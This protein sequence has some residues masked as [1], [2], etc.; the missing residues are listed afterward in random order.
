MNIKTIQLGSLVIALGMLGGCSFSGLD[1]SNKFSCAAPE[2]VMCDS[3]GG[4]YA[5]MGQKTLPGQ[6]VNVKTDA[7]VHG[8]NSGQLSRAKVEEVSPGVLTKPIFSGAP[9]RT[10]PTILRVW[11]APW[12]DTDGDLHDQS[13]IY[14]PID[15]GRWQ[16]EHN[17]R[18]IMDA[19]RPI[20]PPA[21][22]NQGAAPS[23]NNGGVANRF[24]GA[25]IGQEMEKTAEDMEQIQSRQQAMTPEQAAAIFGN[26]QRPSN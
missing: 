25:G 7:A 8:Q 13:Y 19:Y 1:A 18:R 16:I 14:L 4:V 20:K 26:I 15:S 23:N 3:M 21:V 6:N 17:R 10:N 12:E 24:G 5:K 22:S 2:G 9:I 11:I